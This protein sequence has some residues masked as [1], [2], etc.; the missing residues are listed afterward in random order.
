MG[1]PTPSVLNDVVIPELVQPDVAKITKILSVD[2]SQ[3]REALKDLIVR[4]KNVNI[5]DEESQAV[6]F[7]IVVDSRRAVRMAEKIFDPGVRQF[8]GLH[9]IWTQER[10]KWTKPF[11]T[12]NKSITVRVTSYL[13]DQERKKDDL[14]YKHEIESARLAREQAALAQLDFDP[15]GS[16]DGSVPD[17]GIPIQKPFIPTAVDAPEKIE[18]GVAG[19]SVRRKPWK[20]Q[21]DNLDALIVAAAIGILEEKGFKVDITAADGSAVKLA[22]TSARLR[23]YLMADQERL[24]LKASEVGKEISTVIPGV[25]AT[26]DLGITTR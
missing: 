1:T 22:P 18:T 23:A 9:K 2:V 3:L 21:V 11:D 5:V 20:A 7:A 6:A 15:W 8:N 14:R 4:A 26:Q 10:A 13:Q 16:A 17:G 19:V 12:I 24:N 25:S